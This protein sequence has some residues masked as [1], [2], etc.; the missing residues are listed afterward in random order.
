MVPVYSI[1]YIIQS[2]NT[3]T[4]THTDTHRHTLFCFFLMD[5]MYFLFYF[6]VSARLGYI[7]I[8]YILPHS[9]PITFLSFYF[10]GLAFLFCG[11]CIYYSS[12]N[13]HYNKAGNVMLQ[14]RS[15]CSWERYISQQTYSAYVSKHNCIKH[16]IYVTYVHKT[17]K[18]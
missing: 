8:C 6:Y 1:A 17:L 16:Y 11:L 2:P 18:N 5:T 4:D 9:F 7:F 15:L 14:T 10:L 12:H 13:Q 3:H